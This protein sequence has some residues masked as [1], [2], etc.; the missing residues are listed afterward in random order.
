MCNVLDVP[1]STYYQSLNKTISNRER[2]NNKLTKRIIK[3]H[4]DSD[5]RYGAPKIHHLLNEEGYLVSL[6][7]VQRLMKKAK[8]RSITVKKIRPLPSKEK[9]VE[10]E[11][12]LD[13]DF[14]KIGRAHV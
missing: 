6:K 7:R 3:I 5:K 2:E 11:N 8:I 12:I 9:I 10:R 1:R 4:N 14:S 13:R